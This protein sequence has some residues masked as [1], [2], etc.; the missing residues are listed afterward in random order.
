[1]EANTQSTDRYV[2]F[3]LGRYGIIPR[4]LKFVLLFLFGIGIVLYL[5]RL[6]HWTIGGWVLDDYR[7][8]YL[9]YVIFASAVFIYLPARKK[10]ADRIPWY[11]YVLSTL[12]FGICLYFAVKAFK[13]QTLSWVPPRTTYDLVLAYIIAV[14]ALESGRRIAG[15]PLGL[16]CLLFGIYPVFAEHMPGVLYGFSF[17]FDEVIGTFA[18]GSVGILGLPAQV[19]GRLLIGFFIFAG[20]LLVGGAGEF[21]LNVAM[22]LFGQFRG[23]PAKV[24]VIAS[25]FFGS[26]SGSP[27]ANIVSTGS[28][29]IPTMKRLGYPPHYA[30]AIEAAASTGGVIMP[31]VMGTIAFI[32]VVLTDVPYVEIMIA[33]AIPALLYYFG[34]LVQV[35]SYAARAGLKGLSRQE[36]PSFWKTLKQG[37]HFLA[38]LF[39]LVFALIYLRWLGEAAISASVLLIVLSYFRRETMITPKKMVEIIATIGKLIMYIMAVLLPVGMI[40]IG[41][42]MTGTLTAITAEIMNFASTNMIVVLLIAAAVCYLFGMIG[43]AFVPYIVL[44]ATAIP[45]LAASTGLSLIGLHLFTIYYLIMAGI[46]PPVAIAAFIGAAVAGAPPMKTAWTSMRLGVVLFFLPFFFVFNPALVLD[47]PITETLYLFAFCILGIWILASGLEG[48]LLKVGKL[49]LWSRPLLFVGGFLIALPNWMI[50]IAG[51]ALTVLVVAA[52]LMT[53]KSRI[54]TPVSN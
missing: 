3:E 23:G 48:Y 51:L 11:D 4:P 12:L 26:L 52:I 20:V 14:L 17:P 34:L 21:F 2:K 19:T 18:Y 29:T 42:E 40:L 1:V 37:W 41:I 6:Y 45:A 13:I 46:T 9:L 27:M 30:G 49:N 7:Y 31:P 32:M 53:K 15:W 47:G 35:D 44:A 43:L 5:I 33:A 38:A 36:V 22:S 54:K 39:F 10:D 16:I 24:A 25:G 8:F 50:T 28:V